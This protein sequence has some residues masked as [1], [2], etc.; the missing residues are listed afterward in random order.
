MAIEYKCSH[1]SLS[2]FLGCFSFDTSLHGHNQ[3]YSSFFSPIP[4]LSA[5]SVGED[6]LI[7]IFP[8]SNLVPPP[9]VVVMVE[10]MSKGPCKIVFIQ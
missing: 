8:M 7:L 1:L 5:F 6:F 9:M 10:Y 3:G 2:T 4:N